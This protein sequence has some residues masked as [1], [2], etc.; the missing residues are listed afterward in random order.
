MRRLVAD[1]LLL[2]RADAGRAATRQSVDV[3]AIV[4][5]A[6]AELAPLAGDHEL[7]F[8][9][10]EP[11]EGGPRPLVH[12]SAD[13]L[14]RLVLNLVQNA[15]SHTPGGTLIDVTVSIQGDDAVLEV[16][17]D[18][19]GIPDELRPRIFERFVRGDGDAR[20]GG[21]GLGL[22]I[23][24]AV[25]QSHFGTVEL[26]GEDGRPG[27][28]FVVRLPLVHGGSGWLPPTVEQPAASDVSA[29]A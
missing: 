2:A 4:R 27:T 25:A 20:R 1:L 22:A 9:L 6:A 26:A 21:S 23:V 13:D 15:I 28:R 3:A 14:H 29:R 10:P 5:D 11:H 24:Q 7:T 18:G 8:A 17:D 19:P 16:V 12:G